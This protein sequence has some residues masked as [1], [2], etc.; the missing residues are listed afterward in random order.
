MLPQSFEDNIPPENRVQPD[1]IAE[2]RQ[3]VKLARE[4]D[5]VGWE[6]TRK[7]V[8]KHRLHKTRSELAD[9]IM[10]AP[11]AVHVRERLLHA[12][13]EP[14]S[15]PSSGLLKQLTGLPISKAIRALYLYFQIGQDLLENDSAYDYDNE[16][17]APE[18]AAF[19]L[20]NPNPYDFLLRSANPTILDLGAG[21]LSFEEELVDQYVPQLTAHHRA[22]VVHAVDR[23]QPGSQ[24]GGV[25][26]A[27]QE[28]LRKFSTYAPNALQFR[29]WGGI[30]MVESLT[31]HGLRPTYTIV[32]CHAP[33]TP[34]FAYEPRRVSAGIITS[35]LERTKGSFRTIRVHGEEALEVHHRGK[36]LTFPAWKF[37]VQGPRTLLELMARRGRICV[38]SAVDNEVFW[39][40]LSQLVDDQRARPADV[41]FTK[42]NIPD[43]FGTLYQTLSALKVGDRLQ[44]GHLT[45]L[46]SILPYHLPL[47]PSG[48][49]G[50]RFHSV[51]IRR[52]AVF[53]GIPASFTARQFSHMREESPPW[54]LILTSQ[55]IQDL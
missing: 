7:L 1:E 44:L 42:D 24:F 14:G 4:Q 28:R 36:A 20:T 37:V 16:P 12:L 49:S 27:S 5:P 3:T 18:I 31:L 38:L 8:G 40:I 26:H 39:E 50:Y 32:T 33:A 10:Q 54:C 51:E 17:T 53:Q 11:L 29:F 2:F 30:D 41:I 23:L 9:R 45:S 25:Y 35:H 47:K 43:I 46:R 52:G 19:L 22:L 15:D 13:G 55:L 6:A 34:T 21:D 48:S